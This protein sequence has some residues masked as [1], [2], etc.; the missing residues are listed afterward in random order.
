MGCLRGHDG[1]SISVAP[2]ASLGLSGRKTQP[3]ASVS[4]AGQ[5]GQRRVSSV[6]GH[7]TYEGIPTCAGGRVWTPPP[8]PA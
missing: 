6:W 5:V 8:G 1:Q 2:S 3:D 7:S 4:A